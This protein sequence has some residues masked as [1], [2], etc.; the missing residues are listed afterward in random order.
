MINPPP[1]AQSSVPIASWLDCTLC[2]N[3]LLLFTVRTD[4]NRLYLECEECLSGY[5]TIADGAVDDPFWPMD[6]DWDERPA[7]RAN[8]LAA[9]LD[10]AV[11][12]L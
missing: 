5:M 7:S 12:H 9:G 6:T 10:W 8:I 2:N 4:T 1:E 3:G 11:R